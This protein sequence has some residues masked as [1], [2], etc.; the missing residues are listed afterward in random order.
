[1]AMANN[2]NSIDDI[3][4]RRETLRG[5]LD[6]KFQDMCA[7]YKRLTEPEP[8]P[9]GF[10]ARFIQRA[11]NFSYFFDAAFLGYKLYRAFNGGG[12]PLRRL[13]KH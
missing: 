5:E 10:T 9:V 7:S 8:E 2:I 1:M 13:L 4:L 6:K 11:Q 12:K 3:R